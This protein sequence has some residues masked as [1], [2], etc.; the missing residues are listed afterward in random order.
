MTP[1]TI[2]IGSILSGCTD[3]LHQLEP[4]DFT[5]VTERNIFNAAKNLQTPDIVSIA[6]QMHVPIAQLTPFIEELHSVSLR[7]SAL[8]SV[9]RARA[10]R[11][12]KAFH[13]DDF[14]AEELPM[15]LME[16]AKDIRD[17]L[18]YDAE[19]MTDILTELQRDVPRVS[20][21]FRHVDS[22]LD[23][24]IERGAVM[25]VGGFPGDGKTAFATHLTANLL[26][27][28]K[29]VHFVTLEMSRVSLVRR[30]MQ[31]FWEQ[32]QEYVKKYPEKIREMTGSLSVSDTITR[33]TDV[34]GSMSKHLDA[35]L[36]VVDF[37]QRVKDGNHAN[38]RVAEIESVSGA[39]ANFAREFEMPILLLSQYN[40]E[41]KPDR[42]PPQA[43][44]LKGSSALEADSSIIAL[45]HNPNA[46]AESGENY[47][48]V[49]ETAQAFGAENK[50]IRH[51]YI[52]KNR[53]GRIGRLQ[54]EFDKPRS[55]F[56]SL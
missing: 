26:H 21:T 31:A 24:G 53:N 32:P 30:I 8:N 46:K 45:L 16:K 11:E 35:D 29:K 23:G 22:L 33:L 18:N 54:F 10:M 42:E 2:I 44:H 41:Y 51:M 40:R 1:E 27:D 13:P 20:T 50:D 9:K 47:V 52:R 48:D 56:I 4:D 15:K 12:A 38:N 7:F 28:G 34:I 3:V 43:Y 14:T 6:E 25:T 39:I 19:S 37:A 49:E 55:M 36:M 5:G 17:M